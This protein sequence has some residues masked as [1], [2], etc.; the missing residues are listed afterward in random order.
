[1][2]VHLIALKIFNSLVVQQMVT[3]S[4]RSLP[5]YGKMQPNDFFY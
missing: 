1:M 2:C 4:E 3:N 5:K